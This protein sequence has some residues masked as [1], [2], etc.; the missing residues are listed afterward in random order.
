L[1]SLD[2]VLENTSVLE[3][4]DAMKLWMNE[5][6]TL[7]NSIVS[8]GKTY[9]LVWDRKEDFDF[10]KDKLEE[11]NNRVKLYKKDDIQSYITKKFYL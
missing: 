1:T 8:P 11:M 2:D 9:K 10:V 6:G 7:V 3:E 5:K 4:E